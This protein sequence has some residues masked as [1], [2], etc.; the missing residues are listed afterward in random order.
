MSN[1]S[2]VGFFLGRVFLKTFP[3]GPNKH[4]FQIFF[5]ADVVLPLSCPFGIISYVLYC[6]VVSHYHIDECF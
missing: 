1:L 4:G 5:V 2:V 3:V 6:C